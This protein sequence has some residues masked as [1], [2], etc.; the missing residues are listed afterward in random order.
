MTFQEPIAQPATFLATM[1]LKPS[2]GSLVNID[3]QFD[4]MNGELDIPAKNAAFQQF[5]DYLEAYPGVL[6]SE[7][8]G[9]GVSGYKS[10]VSV[11]QVIATG[12]PQIPEEEPEE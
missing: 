2:H 8:D 6:L 1:Y 5:I 12:Y 4:N 3:Y 10:T 7:S 11:Q 9:Y